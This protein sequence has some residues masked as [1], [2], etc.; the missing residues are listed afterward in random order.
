MFALNVKNEVNS[1][2]QFPLRLVRLI[3]SQPARALIGGKYRNYKRNKGAMLT[4]SAEALATSLRTSLRANGYGGIWSN[5]DQ[6]EI[7]LLCTQKDFYILKANLTHLVENFSQNCHK[8]NVIVDSNS[9]ILEEFAKLNKWEGLRIF[10]ETEYSSE[11]TILKKYIDLYNPSRKNWIRQQ[12]LKTLFVSYSELP[13]LIIDSDTFIKP[14]FQPISGGVQQLL[15]GND[16][17]YPYSSHIRKFLKLNPIGLSFV[18]HVQLQQPALVHEIYGKNPVN[19]LRGWLKSGVS[20]AEYSSVSEFQ[21]YGDFIL[22]NYPERVK[23]NFHVHHLHDARKFKNQVTSGLDDALGNHLEGCEC[24][25]VTLAN[26]HLI[27]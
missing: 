25:L 8:I 1:E 2:M 9:K 18:H 5:P 22:Q 13:V 21:T 19:G 7:L 14:G 15:V 16:Y 12:C 24:D 11:L 4:Q 27:E 10:E 20:M 3:S 17:H 6:F 23:V 26:K